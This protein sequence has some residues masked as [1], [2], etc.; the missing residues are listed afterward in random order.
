MKLLC[1]S[2]EYPPLGGGGAP[3]CESICK[4]LVLAGHQVDVLTSHMQHLP[5]A[6]VRDGVRI[7]R[8]PCLRKRIHYTTTTEL[9]TG[10]WPAYRAGLEMIKET[11]YDL[12]H[13]HFVV[14]SGIVAAALSRKSAIPFVLTAH[15]SDIPSYNPDRFRVMHALIRPAWK[16]ILRRASAITTPSA[17]LGNLLQSYME[18]P[19]EIIPNSFSAEPCLGIARRN[20]VL[21]V[22]RLFERKGIQY[23]IDAFR[24]LQTDWELVVAG[25]GPY[26][27]TLHNRAAGAG[28]NVTF[29]GFLKSDELSELYESAKIFVLPSLREN[30]PVVLLEAMAAGCAIITTS[31]SGCEEV[32][33]DAGVIVEP[34]SADALGHSL[35][36]LIEND[37]EIERLGRLALERTSL[38]SEAAIAE[39]FA[40]LFQACVGDAR[41]RDASGAT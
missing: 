32:V 15:G 28:V 31:G 38:F 22:S 9:A 21:A 39:R 5:R 24:E 33:G 26:L 37:G 29:T 13:C 40:S 30:F 7:Y 27:E 23:L 11:G 17:F 35:R 12:I 10:L 36:L 8:T 41:L 3:V 20:R 2:Y 6:E 25:D 19:V 34:Q 1:I 4:S 18:V 16:S 14:P